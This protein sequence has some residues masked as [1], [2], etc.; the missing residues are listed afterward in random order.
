[1]QSFRV[2]QLAAAFS[3]ASLLAANRRAVEIPASKLAV[4]KA[5]ASCRTLKLCIR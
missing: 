2:R 1:M 5:A 3:P 4:G